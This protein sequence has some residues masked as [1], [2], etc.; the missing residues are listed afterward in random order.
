MKLTDKMRETLREWGHQENEIEQ[1]ERAT[2]VT[3][4][5]RNGRTI[6]E[7]DAR[8]LLG[9]RVWLSG[10]SRSAFHWDA[11]R[12]DRYGQTVSFDSRKLFC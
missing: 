5:E 4:Y 11:A 12:I 3:T 8:R 9:T 2:E 7:D 1:I 10:L 6:S